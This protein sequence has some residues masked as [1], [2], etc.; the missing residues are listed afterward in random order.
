MVTKGIFG[1][2]STY[3][4]DIIKI[5]ESLSFE[6][7]KVVGICTHAGFNLPNQGYISKFLD[8][9][10]NLERVEYNVIDSRVKDHV[11]WP[12]KV[13]DLG[14]AGGLWLE[15]K[16]IYPDDTYLSKIPLVNGVA[17][18]I[19]EDIMLKY[20]SAFKELARE[21]IPIVTF[22]EDFERHE[23][24]YLDG[25][26]FQLLEDRVRYKNEKR[27]GDADDAKAQL[28][29]RGIEIMSEDKN[30][31]RIVIKDHSK[32]YGRKNTFFESLQNAYDS[33]REL[34][35]A[36]FQAAIHEAVFKDTLQEYNMNSGRELTF[37][38]VNFISED[39]LNHPLYNHVLEDHKKQQA[40]YLPVLQGAGNGDVQ[41]HKTYIIDKYIRAH[42][43]NGKEYDIPRM[44]I[45]PKNFR[46]IFSM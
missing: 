15:F 42:E 23:H 45:T 43:E 13:S 35:L 4:Y 40:V 27:Y 11:Y 9:F 46:S 29:N 25:E 3:E 34:S 37:G 18:N 1:A 17:G 22:G 6:D 38:K 44:I 28:I 10:P 36:E 14:N 41:K 31:S 7:V 39:K 26:N 30:G 32:T 12:A 16:K 5:D 2:V 20:E 24:K 33:S 8:L 21:D 19:F